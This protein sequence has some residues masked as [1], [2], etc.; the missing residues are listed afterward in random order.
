MKEAF[1]KEWMDDYLSWNPIEYENLTKIRIPC[2]K[3]W[4]PDIVLYNKAC[5]AWRGNW[6]VLFYFEGRLYMNQ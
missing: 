1:Q 2:E 4:L 3:I 6:G 5:C